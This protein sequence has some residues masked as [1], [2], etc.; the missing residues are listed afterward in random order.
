MNTTQTIKTIVT[1]TNG[2]LRGVMDI[3]VEFHK[4]MPC[5]VVHDGHTF[6]ATGKDGTH[7]ATGRSTREMATDG[8]ARLWIT[9]DTT[10]VWED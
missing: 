6:R 3:Q 8:D 10:H 4:T 2:H 1:D 7:I 5:L 9:L